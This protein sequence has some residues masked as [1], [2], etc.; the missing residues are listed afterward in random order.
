MALPKLFRE[1]ISFQ[2]LLEKRKR[3]TLNKFIK[4]RNNN[5]LLLTVWRGDYLSGESQPLRN[6]IELMQKQMDKLN[7][8]WLD[9]CDWCTE[10]CQHECTC[11]AFAGACAIQTVK[12][13]ANWGQRVM[14]NEIQNQKK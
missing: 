10:N 1:L 5:L 4:I 11:K 3:E 14:F 12:S 7:D 2:N 6:N 8:I 13:V 9:L